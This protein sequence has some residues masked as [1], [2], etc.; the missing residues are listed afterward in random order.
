MKDKKLYIYFGIG[1]GVILILIAI[2]FVINLLFGGRISYTKAEEKMK[3]AAIKYFNEHSDQLP[4]LNNE[5][6]IGMEELVNENLIK[7]FDRLLKNKEASCTGNVTVRN[8]NYY[9]QYIPYIDC[10][11]DYQTSYLYQ[12]IIND[13][14][15]VTEGNGLYEINDELV[16]RGEDLNNYI[17]FADKLWR[18]IKINNDHSIRIIE[19][20]RDDNYVWDNRYNI[21]VSSSNGIND[22][23]VSRIKDSIEEIYQSEDEFNEKEKSYIV[24]HNVCLDSKS[25]TDGISYTCSNILEN[26]YISLLNA[27]EYMIASIDNNCTKLNDK[28]CA[29]YNYIANFSKSFWTITAN[30]SRTDKVFKIYK[31]PDVTYASNNGSIQ[32]VIHLS[33]KTIYASG[34]GTS[35]DPYKIK[36]A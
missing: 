17:S 29:N 27:N 3:N 34:K 33:G 19:V 4:S 30:S 36:M 23:R 24:A 32:V 28:Q 10:G 20:N 16:F 8:N 12:K 9:Y 1:T 13:N 5:V 21:S 22:Y 15:V 14:N 18:I 25:E 35:E 6:V 26:Q 31:I 7:N 2:I 11:N